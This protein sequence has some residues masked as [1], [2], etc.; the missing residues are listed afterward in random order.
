MGGRGGRTSRRVQRATG[1]FFSLGRGREERVEERPRGRPIRANG[2]N[3]LSG[4]GG[5]KISGTYGRRS[6]VWAKRT[7]TTRHVCQQ[8]GT[9]FRCF[10]GSRSRPEIYLTGALSSVKNTPDRGNPHCTLR[11][12][13]TSDCGGEK[14]P[15]RCAGALRARLGFAGGTERDLSFWGIAQEEQHFT[16]LLYPIYNGFRDLPSYDLL[17]HF[18]HHRWAV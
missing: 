5:H 11:R 6:D 3:S 2:R 16:C 1:K 4:N 7:A 17:Y 15:T 10:S 12:S 14:V 8:A 13:S 9:L 18:N